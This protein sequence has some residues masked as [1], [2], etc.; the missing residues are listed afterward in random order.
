MPSRFIELPVSAATAYAQLQTAALAVELARDVSHLQGSF[1]TKQ[2]KGSSQWYFSFREPN[3]RLRQIYVGP[4]NGDV[5]ALVARAREAAPLERLKPLARSALALGCTPTQRK[6]LSVI[7]RINEF[8]FLRAGGVLVGTHAFLSYANQLGLRW[9][10]SDQTADV[11]FAHAGRN[12]SIALPAT[13]QAHPHSALTTMA[14]GFLPLVQFRG[15]AGASYRHPNEPEFQVDFLT[16]R[17]ADNDDPITID[18][19]DVAMQP[20]RFME[21]SLESVQ[22]ATLFDP[23]GRCVVVSLPAPERYAVH[24]LLIVGERTGTFKSKV[25]KDLAQAASLLEYFAGVDPDAV[26]EAWA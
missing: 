6:H 11:D 9:N 20:L 25:S 24:K 16:P 18:H 10:D 1:S 8:G 17:I 15:G 14:E 26:R 13:V 2:V 5:R 3:Q 12:L 21:F 7:L 23:T 22:Q 19:I 4:D